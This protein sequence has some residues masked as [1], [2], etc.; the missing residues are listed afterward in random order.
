MKIINVLPRLLCILSL[1]V[2]TS[3]LRAE[4]SFCYTYTAEGQISSG[5]VGLLKVDENGHI[6]RSEVIDTTVDDPHGHCPLFPK[7]LAISGDHVI[8]TSEEQNDVA[9]YDISKKPYHFIPFKNLGD[10][11]HHLDSATISVKTWQHYALLSTDEGLFYGIDLLTGNTQGIWDAHDKLSPPGNKGEDISLIPEKD[12]AVLTFQKDSGSGKKKGCRIVVC[13]L[14][15]FFPFM[16]V[17][18]PVFY[19][20]RLSRNHPELH[21]P[22]ANKEQ[23]P[24]PEV[25]IFFSK[26]NRL[27]VTCD[28]YGTVLLMDLNAALQG[29]IENTITIPTALDGSLGRAFPDRALGFTISKEDEQR[30]YLFVGN[31]AKDGGMVIVDVKDEKIVDQFP[32]E[33]G[34]EIPVYLPLS[35]TLVTTVSGK[36]K[37]KTSTG[38]LSQKS[39][40]GHDL[41][42]MNLDPLLKGEHAS[43]ERISF[44]QPITHVQSLNENKSDCLLLVVG[45]EFVI[46]DLASRKIIDHQPSIGK[47][48]RLER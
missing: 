7:K 8:V 19:D 16:R 37:T 35:N 38:I 21:I 42:V 39:G 18:S 30:D 5:G 1:V 9:I 26:E 2:I 41:L 29:K 40:A 17:P 31:A 3:T 46:Y 32:S 12:L 24:N 13:S 44:D 47:V 20:L 34:V 6:I 28:L 14:D 4:E 23:G 15:K 45:N 33:A 48:V 43:L 25:P 36:V 22:G 27:A 11:K 10:R